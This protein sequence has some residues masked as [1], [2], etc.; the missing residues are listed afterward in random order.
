MHHTFVVRRLQMSAV[1]I[2]V[3]RVLT[4]YR[5]NLS[6]E[7]NWSNNSS[8][9]HDEPGVPAHVAKVEDKGRAKD[10]QKEKE[11]KEI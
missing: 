8:L 11:L 6:P 7:L 1:Q 9:H 2:I 4:H 10:E 3:C 5:T